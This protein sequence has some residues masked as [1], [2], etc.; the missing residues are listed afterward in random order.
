MELDVPF[1]FDRN[2]RTASSTGRTDH[3]RDL[4]EA[5]LFTS[6][7]ER[8]NRPTFGCGLLDLVFIGNTQ[9][10]ASTIDMTI[11]ASL[12]QWLG[13]LIAVDHATV[14]VNEATLT[15][16]I[17]YILLATDERRVDTFKRRV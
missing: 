10:L 5:V 2:G 1:A 11:R 3:V 15:I 4:V 8:V 7:G 14:D 16:K 17:G 6:P 13:S 12:Q 9:A